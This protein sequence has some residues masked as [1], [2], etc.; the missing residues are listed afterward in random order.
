MICIS[1][2][3][4]TKYGIVRINHIYENSG[5]LAPNLTIITF[6]DIGE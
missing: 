6:E 4:C 2:L 3:I 1:V 5:I